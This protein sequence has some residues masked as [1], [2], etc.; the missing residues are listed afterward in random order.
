MV[1]QII[2]PPISFHR[3]FVVVTESDSVHY[4]LSHLLLV[5]WHATAE[6]HMS[7]QSAYRTGHFVS[8]F[9]HGESRDR[10]RGGSRLRAPLPSLSAG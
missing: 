7:N 10:W 1:L 3:V 5:G 2:V 8:I 6:L 4:H 9:A